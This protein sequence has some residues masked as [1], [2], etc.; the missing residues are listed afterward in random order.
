MSVH[1]FGSPDAAWRM[2]GP[3]AYFARE[4]RSPDLYLAVAEW[5]AAAPPGAAWD[6]E[7]HDAR[8]AEASAFRTR[9]VVAGTDPVAIDAWCV[10]HLLMPLRGARAGLY[11]LDHPDA[12]VTRF[13][14]YY[15]QVHGSGTLD[16]R[17][18][19]VG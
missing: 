14:R 8:L 7:R 18:V 5:V 17:L 10:R 6:D 4:V 19:T 13:L 9:T 3:L 15:R 12:D 11:D 2:A 1:H 16:E